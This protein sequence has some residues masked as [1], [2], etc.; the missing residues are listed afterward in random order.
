MVLLESIEHLMEFINMPDVVR[1][2]KTRWLCNIY[3][4]IYWSTK[5]CTFNVHLMQYV[6]MMIGIC[7]QNMMASKWVTWVKPYATNHALFLTT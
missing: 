6:I 1:V 2:L 5:K 3:Q 4:L 7:K